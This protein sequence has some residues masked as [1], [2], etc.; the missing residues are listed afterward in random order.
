MSK[1]SA[2]KFYDEII[3]KGEQDAWF[4]K[5]AKEIEKIIEQQ[6][7]SF[8]IDE[9]KEVI[10]DNISSQELS[11]DELDLVAGGG[12]SANCTGEWYIG[13][14]SATVESGSW[15][16]SN[17]DCVVWEVTYYCTNNSARMSDTMCIATGIYR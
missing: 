3:A 8:T 14:C 9:L 2:Q 13:N 17:D 12:D 5:S 7:L 15:C 16:M 11:L 10:K 1:E 6:S 4:S